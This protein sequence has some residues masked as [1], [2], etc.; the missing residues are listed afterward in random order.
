MRQRFL[1]LSKP[2][3]RPADALVPNLTVE[4]QLL[5]AAELSAGPRVPAAERAARVAEVLRLLR[6]EPLRAARIGNAWLPGITGTGLPRRAPATR[7]WVS[8]RTAARLC[9]WRGC[10]GSRTAARLCW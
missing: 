4:A 7:I 5:Y 6:L 3:R 10:R 8:S 2:F 9:W 1:P